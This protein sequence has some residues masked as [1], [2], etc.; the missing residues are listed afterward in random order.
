VQSGVRYAGDH[1]L[2]GTPFP[3]AVTRPK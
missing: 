2:D 3:G 1:M